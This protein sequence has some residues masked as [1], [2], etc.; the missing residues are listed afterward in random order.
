MMTTRVCVLRSARQEVCLDLI[1]PAA[2]TT[3]R[4]DA[5]TAEELGRCLLEEALKAKARESQRPTFAVRGWI[6]LK[7]TALRFSSPLEGGP[8]GP[9]KESWKEKHDAPKRKRILK[10]GRSP[11]ASG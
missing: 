4:L 5:T 11:H 2:V 7:T 1:L 8:R 3:L 10:S 9:D 6:N